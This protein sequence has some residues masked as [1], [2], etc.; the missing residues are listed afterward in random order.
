MGNLLGEGFPEEIIKQVEQ[1]QKIYGE[2]YANNST[3]SLNT[4]K[5]L[6]TNTSWCKLVSSVDITNQDI[7]VNK[8]LQTLSDIGDN[9]LA[10]KFV[11]F[12]GT[13]EH[14]KLRA[15]IDFNDNILSENAYGIGG[16]EFGPRP[17]MGIKSA[18]IKHE[19][20]GSIRRA[21]VQIKAWNKIQFDIIDALYLR[22]GFNILLEWGHV[23]YF[24]NNGEYQENIGNSL[25]ELFLTGTYKGKDLNYSSFLKLIEKRR[26][27]TFGNY[28][29]MFAKVSNMHWS[30]LKDGSY[31]ITLDLVSVGDVI[32]SFKINSLNPSTVSPISPASSP[33]P[34][35]DLLDTPIEQLVT[36]L[37]NQNTINQYFTQMLN[38]M[39]SL[40]AIVYQLKSGVVISNKYIT[41]FAF[42][43]SKYNNKGGLTDGITEV[44]SHGEYFYCRL[45]NFLEFIQNNVLYQIGSQ[46]S[47]FP[48]MK[49]DTQIE[50]NLM[51]IN[52]L[53]VSTDPTVCV[54]NRTL[55][56][57]SL[58]QKTQKDLKFTSV[59][60]N[61]ISSFKPPS[62]SEY[63]QIMNIYVNVRFIIM[64]MDELKD[65]KGNLSLI[66]FLK[67]ILAG[68][69]G[70]L[71]GI[72]E[73]DAFI[74]EITN[75][76]KIID[77]NPMPD[78]QWLMEHINDLK[79]DT[80]LNTKYATFELYGY[81]TITNADKTITNTA[82]FI[83][84]FNFKTELSPAMSTMITVGA[85]ANG[86]VVGENSTALSRLNNG[87][88]D[89]FKP[90]IANDTS[91]LT[92]L[93]SLP[94]PTNN[95]G[96]K[97]GNLWEGVDTGRSIQ[98][99]PPPAPN[100]AKD[101]YEKIGTEYL[102]FYNNFI[103]YLERLS[104][105]KF[106]FEEISTYKDALV[107]YNKAYAVF[108][109]AK[110]D[111][112]LARNNQDPVKNET[113]QP[114]T[115]FIPFNLS[116]TMDGLSGMKINSKFLIDT[117]YLPSNYPN[118]VDFLIK[119]LSH[120]IEGNKWETMLESYCISKGEYKEAP[121]KN[122][123]PK[124]QKPVQE[125]TQTTTQTPINATSG[126]KIRN[127]GINITTAYQLKIHHDTPVFE[128]DPSN[129]R[130]GKWSK[131]KSGAYMYDMVLSREENGITTNQPL[132]PSPVSGR[133]TF[134]G[135]YKDGN[136]AIE[137]KANDGNIYKLLHM[138]KYTVKVGESVSRG[139][140]IGRQ[141][142][143]MP[144]KTKIDG[145][146]TTVSPNV[147]LHIQF[148]S[149]E[150]LISYIDSLNTNNFA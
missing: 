48:L 105:W 5:Y 141:S 62:N 85:V 2:G 124:G 50:S 99:P 64:K 81:N 127:G 80:K 125:Q 3:R 143:I 66:D 60:E 33:N 94:H 26:L 7:L 113:M 108:K 30:F 65:E 45:G 40:N 74:D 41:N 11:L 139:Q 90:F 27:Q 36:L 67:G 22:L 34:P 72:N 32:E 135:V 38:Q 126:W 129:T 18:N 89:R 102:I 8:S 53:Q 87:Y 98:P 71:G 95:Q 1:R 106:T 52:P 130:N 19:N 35:V 6:N 114:S 122:I 63:G 118:T 29:A 55:K 78:I 17:M 83:K 144:P 146:K 88:T 68:I 82:G 14:N 97:V 75:T 134:A 59:G 24:D 132:V 96:F 39:R 117:S 44:T 23:S 49:I 116:L 20:R 112:I 119:G 46:N 100:T 104:T 31:D 13:Q 16:N 79:V 57:N 123:N 77:K 107:N 56:V 150:V 115:G 70:A 137:I 92:P 12:N 140:I 131:T 47:L 110:E 121:E 145:G 15:G 4:L 120:K 148:P 37:S 73:L 133:V 58:R 136:S 43:Q 21:T 142:N 147:H 138:D 86:T 103:G 91:K 10:R 9:K 28:D 76:I 42:N 101:I 54:V 84:D 69:N 93:S 25:E 61:F 128:P 111:Y 51:Y 109:K 149:K